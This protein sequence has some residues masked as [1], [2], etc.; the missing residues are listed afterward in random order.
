MRLYDCILI[1]Y[2]GRNMVLELVIFSFE[3]KYEF[4]VWHFSTHLHI[5][6]F[7]A[8]HPTPL[9]PSVTAAARIVRA[10][11]LRISRKFHR[12][13]MYCYSNRVWW[14]GGR[15]GTILH[16]TPWQKWSGYIFVILVLSAGPFFYFCMEFCNL[17]VRDR[18]K[19]WEWEFRRR[20]QQVRGIFVYA[21]LLIA[22]YLRLR[23]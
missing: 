20:Q 3:E 23:C 17:C 12:V 22:F 14:P 9:S 21:Y 1:A 2:Y 13:W 16:F 18:V 11:A 5:T 19:L 8:P 10:R 6:L 15:G 4:L 7:C